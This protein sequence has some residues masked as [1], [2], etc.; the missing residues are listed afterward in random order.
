VT[1]THIKWKLPKVPDG[2]IGSPVAVGDYL[3][4]LQNP[5]ILKC[6]HMAD[7]KE[8]YS[9]RLN[10]ASAIPSPVATADGRI[11]FANGGKSFVVQAGP[12]VEL[13]GTNDLGDP[14]HA[15]P[16]VAD[17]RLFIKGGRNVYCI[18]SK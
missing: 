11:Y 1:K 7:G 4:R 12:K 13:L 16:A 8:Q 9:E 10:G 3:Y 18:G 2:S 17:G 14:S 6:Y 5:D 15:S